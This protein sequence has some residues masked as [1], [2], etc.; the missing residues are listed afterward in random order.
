MKILKLALYDIK[1]FVKNKLN[2]F[3]ILVFGII[4]SSFAL[5]LYYFTAVSDT[6]MTMGLS[7][8]PREAKVFF[9]DDVSSHELSSILKKYSNDINSVYML[10]ADA[11]QS[12][13]F[14]FNEESTDN[15]INIGIIGISNPG[16]SLPL[17][18]GRYFDES[19][20][21]KN[22]ALISSGIILSQGNE[23]IEI[24]GEAY[25][26][27]GSVKSYTFENNIFIDIDRYIE[28]GYTTNAAIIIFKDIPQQEQIEDLQN[29]LNNLNSNV[30]FIPPTDITFEVLADFF[31]TISIALLIILLSTISLV[32]LYRYWLRF[33]TRTYVIYE[34]CGMKKRTLMSIVITEVAIITTVGFLIGILIYILALKTFNPTDIYRYPHIW[35][36]FMLYLFILLSGIIPSL[37]I[38]RRINKKNGM[39]LQREDLI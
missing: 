13:A 5:N 36:L 7:K 15:E 22:S 29:T 8:M 30:K 20:K 9:P 25:S 38:V 19:D 4:I 16:A 33:N 17:N 10:N 28:N 26:V 34:V 1:E 6:E 11:F 12:S 27:I 14:Y 32:S 39:I 18:S 3:L 31:K 37:I 24:G 35:E 2:I 23:T 21:G